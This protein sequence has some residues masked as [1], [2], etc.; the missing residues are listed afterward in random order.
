M[1]K[2]FIEMLLMSFGAF[3]PLIKCL[4]CLNK[5]SCILANQIVFNFL[6]NIMYLFATL[7]EI[8]ITLNRYFIIKSNEKLLTKKKDIILVVLFGIVSTVLFIP[9]FFTFK[10]EK[11][12]DNNNQEFR[13]VETDFGISFFFKTYLQCVNFFENILTIFVLI[14]LNIIVILEYKKFIRKK[15]ILTQHFATTSLVINEL[16]NEKK[17]KILNSEKK[18]TK[19]I[20]IITFLFIYIRLVTTGVEIF[21]IYNEYVHEIE[22]FSI[23]Y[24]FLNI[25]IYYNVYFTFSFNFF[26]YYYF[27]KSFRDCFKSIFKRFLCCFSLCKKNNIIV[28]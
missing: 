20:L 23:L 7:I 9:T 19:M 14:P 10:I 3:I 17:N 27:N 1:I 13:L 21:V 5:Y 11:Y 12:S 24:V 26:I 2:S 16:Q 8:A 15:R 28:I 22:I 18:F 6:T 25:F 4:T